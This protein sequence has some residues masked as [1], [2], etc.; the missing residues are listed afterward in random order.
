MKIFYTVS[1]LCSVL[2]FVFLMR[3]QRLKSLL[4]LVSIGALL[5]LLSDKRPDIIAIEGN[6]YHFKN[7]DYAEIVLEKKYQNIG[8]YQKF[9]RSG[10]LLEKG[11]YSDGY[12]ISEE[13][14]STPYKYSNSYFWDLLF[15]TEVL[16]IIAYCIVF[17]PSDYI[18]IRDLYRN[19]KL[20]PVTYLTKIEKEKALGEKLWCNNGH[21]KTEQK[22]IEE[23]Y[24]EGMHLIKLQCPACSAINNERIS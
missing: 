24:K 5:F 8:S 18:F 21:E 14:Q 2:G 1:L 16:L 6:K 10:M 20:I 13:Q 19:H 3:K 9:S 22:V 12:F 15:V 17:L 11:R 23:V 4:L 7:G